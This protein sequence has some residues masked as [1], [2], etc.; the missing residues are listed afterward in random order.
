[1]AIILAFNNHSLRLRL[2][3]CRVSLVEGVS[4]VWEV[5]QTLVYINVCS[6]NVCSSTVCSSGVCLCSVLLAP[7]TPLG[8]WSMAL[9]LWQHLKYYY[10]Y[11]LLRKVLER[12]R[13]FVRF[14]YLD[15]RK[16]TTVGRSL[17]ACG[18]EP[19]LVSNWEIFSIIIIIIIII[20][21]RQIEGQGGPSVYVANH[22]EEGFV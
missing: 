8:A 21:N 12:F 6:S 10:Y 15:T 19:T 13:H 7:P 4:C 22:Y 5:R 14:V 9:V 16:R 18:S 11:Y 17:L 2:G 20:N 3:N 1:M